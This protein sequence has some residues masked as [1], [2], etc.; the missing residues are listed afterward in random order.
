MSVGRRWDPLP[1]IITHSALLISSAIGLICFSM[2]ANDPADEFKYGN[3]GSVL[4]SGWCLACSI[5]S[6]IY[7]IV[8]LAHDKSSIDF[9][10]QHATFLKCD[11]FLLI[12]TT[13]LA[14]SGAVLW[15]EGGTSRTIYEAYNTGV[16]TLWANF[17]FNFLM[18]W[19]DHVSVVNYG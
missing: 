18:L 14:I 10:R 4:F 1:C 2:V 3:M 17:L 16:V 7:A 5:L 9:Q 15:L 6:F 12:M 13:P 19:Q 11:V 8:G